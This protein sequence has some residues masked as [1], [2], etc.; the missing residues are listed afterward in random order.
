VTKLSP[1]SVSEAELKEIFLN[2]M[3]LW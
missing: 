2:S 1:R 3:T